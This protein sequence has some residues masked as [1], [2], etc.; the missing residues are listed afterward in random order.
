[1]RAIFDGGAAGALVRSG[2]GEEAPWVG[3]MIAVVAA[4]RR[5]AHMGA[6]HFIPIDVFIFVNS[7]L[8][9]TNY[10]SSGRFALVQATAKAEDIFVTGVVVV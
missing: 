1:M 9:R 4:W 7:T 8:S 5:G 2:G 6:I 3:I 10:T